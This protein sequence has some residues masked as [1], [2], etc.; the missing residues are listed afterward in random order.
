MK[1]LFLGSCPLPIEDG[2]PIQGPGLRTWQLIKPV[3]DAGHTVMAFLLRTE[4]LYEET[5]NETISSTPYQ[6]LMMYNMSYEA[7]TNV[8]Q[9][10]K[11]AEELKPD[12]IIGAASVL[13]NY[14]ASQLA[15]IAPFWADCFGDPITEIQ[16]KCE[17]YGREG[18]G[19]ELLGVWKYYRA[20]LSRADQFSALSDAQNHAIVGQLGMLGR[21]GFE[22]SGFPLINTIPCGVDTAPPLENPP[23][24]FLRGVKYPQ[25]AF[26][27][28]FSG[29]YNTWM[30]VDYL[31][32]GMEEAMNRLPNFWFLSIG[33]GTKGY[34]E[35]LYQD[36]CQKVENSPNRERYILCGWVPF[37][38]VPRYYAESTLGVNIDRF[39]YEGVLGSRNRILQFLAYGLPVISTPLS[40][41]S[42]Q[43]AK[44]GLIYC[45]RM[46]NEKG[47]SI[48]TEPLPDLLV[49]LS[50]NLNNVKQTG[51]LA[52]KI[53]KTEYSFKHTA[54]PLLDW[55]VSPDC[56]P[57]NKIR[58][59]KPETAE[60]VYLN[61]IERLND[62][63]RIQKELESLRGE[64]KQLDAIRKVPLYRILRRIKQFIHRA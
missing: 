45:F 8:E 18:C 50:E 27:V 58:M 51:L 17:I 20:V 42:V 62:F 35:K 37:K 31:F 22:T 10:R 47:C 6:N 13:P 4:G 63:E 21:L 49:H 48:V 46:R 5:L 44:R 36:F 12:A 23:E 32:E 24:P 52:Q 56:A 55:L 25:D 9:M 34:N 3:C 53:V 28:C 30:D 64:K 60:P 33:G 11:K 15:D 16:A 39:S 41:I 14:I 26:V 19:N 59:E 40:E 54:A 29:S 2:I 38:E 7:F 43:L 61:E 57:D 1:V